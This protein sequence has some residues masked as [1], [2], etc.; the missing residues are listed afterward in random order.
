MELNRSIVQA[1]PLQRIKNTLHGITK[2]MKNHVRYTDKKGVLEW[3]L[4]QYMIDTNGPVDDVD[5]P[6][7]INNLVQQK[8]NQFDYFDENQSKYS[9]TIDEVLNELAA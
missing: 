8:Q 2:K 1:T 7:F 6:A 3:I 9:D 4:I 5:V